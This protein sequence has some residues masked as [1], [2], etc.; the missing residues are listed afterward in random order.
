MRVVRLLGVG[1]TLVLASGCAA[2]PTLGPAAAEL[3]KDTQRLE[4]DLFDNPLYKLRILQRPDK[5]IECKR[6]KYRRVLRATA[7][8][9]QKNPDMDVHLDLAQELM[10]NTL[11][12]DLGYK[13]DYDFTQRDRVD[14]RF[15]Y[16]IKED[17]GI[18]LTVYVAPEHPTWRLHA[19]TA[20]LPR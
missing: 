3:L 11:A 4:T 10:Q 8:Y 12:Q 16:A 6:D 2:E 1:L 5:D 18:R 17:P 15:I 19:M 14:G 7:D 13:M 9:E 20:C